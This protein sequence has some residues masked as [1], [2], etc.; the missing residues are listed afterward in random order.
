MVYFICS[1][2]VEAVDIGNYKCAS[3]Y[4]GEVKNDSNTVELL[5]NP[6]KLEF[7]H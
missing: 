5:V 4:T 3:G 1:A 7:S 6:G 2:D